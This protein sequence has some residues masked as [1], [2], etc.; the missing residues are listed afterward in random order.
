MEP[1][2]L[3]WIMSLVDE[4]LYSWAVGISSALDWHSPRKG[5]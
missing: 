4:G 2:T 3:P 1:L 5:H